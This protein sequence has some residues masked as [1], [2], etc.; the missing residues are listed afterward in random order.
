MFTVKVSFIIMSLNV[1]ATD[2]EIRSFILSDSRE[3]LIFPSV[4]LDNQKDIKEQFKHYFKEYIGLEYD[5]I[6][7]KLLD[8]EQDTDTIIMYYCSN[9]PIE[10]KINN[11]V[12]IPTNNYIHKEIVQKATRYL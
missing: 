11:G 9:I 12:F 4:I 7:H 10:T 2:K 8:I 3:S 6:E 1:D 5:W